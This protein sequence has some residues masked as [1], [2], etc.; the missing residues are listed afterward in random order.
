[1]LPPGKLLP[2]RQPAYVASWAYMFGVA[3]LAVAVAS[4]FALALGGPDWWHYNTLGHFFNSMHLWSV[5]LFMALLVIHLWAKFW[6][7]AG[8]ATLLLLL[9]PFIPGLRDLPRL[10]PVHRLIWRSWYRSGDRAGS[11]PVG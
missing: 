5:E 10:V 9:V 3:A 4:G 8:L 6:M 2:D 7:A 1:V 11:G